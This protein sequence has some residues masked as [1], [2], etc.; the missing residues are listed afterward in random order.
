MYTYRV[1]MRE[2]VHR[3]F[4]MKFLLL[5]ARTRALKTTL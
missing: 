4:D 1:T 5:G 3:K 2:H